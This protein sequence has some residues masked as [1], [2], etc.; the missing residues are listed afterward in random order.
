MVRAAHYTRENECISY[1]EMDYGNIGNSFFSL[2]MCV[3][4][5]SKKII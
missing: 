3:G 1:I 2:G 4:M 5:L